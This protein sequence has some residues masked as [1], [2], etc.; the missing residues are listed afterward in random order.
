M[1]RGWGWWVCGCGC[2]CGCA[3]LVAALAAVVVGAAD[4]LAVLHLRAARAVGLGLEVAHLVGPLYGAAAELLVL[5]LVV[6]LEQKNIWV[7][8][9]LDISP[10]ISTFWL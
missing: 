2:G 5:L 9:T 1:G 8:L 10:S 3:R 4:Q 7:R 6:A